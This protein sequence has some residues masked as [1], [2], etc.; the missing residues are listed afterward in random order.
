M[1]WEFSPEDVVKAQAE[2]GL[3]DFRRDLAE[4][5][6]SNPRVCRRPLTGPRRST[7]RPAS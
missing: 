7:A 4:E 5:L 6:R 3:L 1:Q 2:Y